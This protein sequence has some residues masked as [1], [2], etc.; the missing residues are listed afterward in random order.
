MY[1][2]NE[3]PAL[4]RKKHQLLQLTQGYDISTPVCANRSIMHGT[5]TL[6]SRC[7]R[8]NGQ[9]LQNSVGASCTTNRSN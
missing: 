9:L 6:L 4:A 3:R 7:V 5:R 8:G 1:L 2:N